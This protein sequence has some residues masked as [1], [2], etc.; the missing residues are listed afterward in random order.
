V[1]FH[2]GKITDTSLLKITRVRNVSGQL[3]DAK[4]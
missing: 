3:L 4:L 2:Y 1:N